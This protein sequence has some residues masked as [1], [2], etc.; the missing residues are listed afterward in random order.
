MTPLKPTGPAGDESPTVSIPV[1]SGGR[2]TEVQIGR[3]ADSDMVVADPL[4]SRA[5]ATLV[6][7][8][9]GLVI[10]DNDSINGTF[11]NGRRIVRSALSDGD[12]VT[13]GNTDFTVAGGT[14]VLRPVDHHVGG[15]EAEQLGLTIDGRQL[16]DDVSLT[17]RPGTLTAVIGP[18]GAGKSTLINLLGGAMQP[19]IGRVG[20]D[21]HD[22][23][24]QY[25]SL[26]SRIGVVPQDDVVHRQLT[27]EQALGY[28]AELRLPPD[29]SA[30]DRRAVVD[31]VIDELELTPH[32]KT[33]VDKLSGGQRKRAS[34]AMELLTGPSL[35]ILDEPT[36]GLDPA[37]DRQVMTMLRRLADADR[38]VVVVT[39]SLTYLDMCDQ[40]LLLAPGGKTAFSG[41]PAEIGAVMGGTDWAD[42]FAF[43]SADPDAAHREYLAR[44]QD[45]RTVNLGAQ[46]RGRAGS[47]GSPARTSLTRQIFSVAR[48]QVR[49]IT[50][51][52]GYFAFLAL[53]PFVLG[54][55]ALV[56]PGESGF[57]IA[58]PRGDSPEEA[59]AILLVLLVSVVF[60]GTALTI[61]DLVGE[62]S[63]FRR[64]QSVGLSASAYLA[65]K[66]L[67]FSAAALVQ[68]AVLTAI[69]VAG[70]GA[71]TRGALL[72]G[73]PVVE[74]YLV[75]ALTAIVSAVIGLAL[76][77]MA[78]STEQI[79][80]MLVVVIMVSLVF[81]GGMFP[82][83]TRFGLSQISWYL[84]S[85]WG[86]AAAAATV[87]VTAI[88]PLAAHDQLW[89]HEA[90]WWLA[91]MAILALLGVVWAGVVRWQLRLP[92]RG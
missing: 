25:A 6:T 85:R 70:K 80:P 21:G 78:K 67:V 59:S 54:A 84:P 31:R 4:V 72:L 49:L 86:Y 88:D 34:V 90:R 77:A 79:L 12:V 33:R 64:E 17:A 20:F 65:A 87:D 2:S 5:H 1:M 45:T 92:R 41:P 10:I 55:L 83:G 14:L 71:P 32:R 39:H 58:D 56:V 51:D 74:L 11:V 35:L 46:A 81:S 47:A 73:S 37:L 36:S 29:T 48:R 15:L 60:M 52:R 30:A 40:V 42:I 75:L 9:A 43:V 69:V 7:T 53:L 66:V 13:F 24:A 44:R 82:I 18:S 19:S 68:T 89:T 26:R 28:A 61:R 76:S 63:I 22:V 57:G 62:R 38:V 50:A 3:R 8:G 27:V 23:H 91:D 16:L